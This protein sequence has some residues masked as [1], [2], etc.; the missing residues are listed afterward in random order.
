[1]TICSTLLLMESVSRTIYGFMA[2]VIGLILTSL[3][4]IKKVC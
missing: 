3:C 4:V 1:M 2:V